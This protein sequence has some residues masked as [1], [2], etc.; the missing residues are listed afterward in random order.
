MSDR[1]L[2]RLI[3]GCGVMIRFREIISIPELNINDAGAQLQP[4][5][6]TV[7]QQV[8]PERLC[9]RRNAEF[10]ALR[11]ISHKCFTQSLT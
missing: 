2:E 7:L 9:Q 1:L 8:R 6:H 5:E 4:Q 10:A 11:T 3:G